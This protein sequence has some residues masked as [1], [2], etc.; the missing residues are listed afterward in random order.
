MSASINFNGVDMSAGGYGVSILYG[1]QLPPVPKPHIDLQPIPFGGGVTQGRYYEPLVFS[2]DVVI[3]A[4][5]PDALQANL[6]RIAAEFN[7]TADKELW[8]SDTPYDDRYWLGR[9]SGVSG[10]T[11][12]GLASQ[13]YVWEFVAADPV[14]QSRT[15]TTQNVGP[16]GSPE[17]FNMPA[18]G[19]VAGSDT[20]TPIYTLT[21]TGANAGPIS[22]ENTTRTETLTYTGSLN[23]THLLK[24]D[25]DQF[26]I[27]KSTDAGVTWTDVTANLTAFGYPRLTHGVANAFVLTGATNTTLAITYR[28]RLLGG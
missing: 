16:V 21:G 15:L 1:S 10:P 11:D 13:E 12:P 5:S 19:V 24:I 3:A 2:V 4:A 7:V 23:N 17:N 26:T 6:C 22:I 9:R 28:S 25:S 20:A 27:T 14:A 8:F 18:A